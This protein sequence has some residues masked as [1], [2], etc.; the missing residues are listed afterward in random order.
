M[1]DFYRMWGLAYSWLD[2]LRR[3]C[4]D[5]A[6][7]NHALSKYAAKSFKLSH[8]NFQGNISRNNSISYFLSFFQ[9]SVKKM[10]KIG[11]CLRTEFVEY[12]VCKTID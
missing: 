5:F 9:I 7:R 1:R 8:K 10:N 4:R 11:Y 6:K 2:V 3:G 12:T